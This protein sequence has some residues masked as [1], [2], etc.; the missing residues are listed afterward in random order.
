MMDKTIRKAVRCYLI[1]G[2]KVV[3]TKYNEPS[4]KAGYYDIPG[5]KIEDGETPE[6]TVIREMVEET[7]LEV[8]NMKFKGKTIIEYPNRIF[9]LMYLYAM[10]VKENHKILKKIH[11]NGWILMNY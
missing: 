7:G 9:D 2:N 3:V 8:K 1:K 5:G 4:Q 10:N 6:Q 11:Q